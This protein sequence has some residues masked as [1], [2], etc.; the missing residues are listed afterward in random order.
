MKA[1]LDDLLIQFADD[2]GLDLEAYAAGIVALFE[3]ATRPDPDPACDSAEHV[4][5][6]V[7]AME[8]R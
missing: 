5:T 4:T 6:D 3:R 2:P 8:E 7:T 1:V